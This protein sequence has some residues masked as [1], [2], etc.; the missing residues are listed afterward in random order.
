M[1][2]RTSCSNVHML[3]FSHECKFS[4]FFKLKGNL[5]TYTVHVYLYDI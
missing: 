3:T 2:Q 5:L 4:S 1:N